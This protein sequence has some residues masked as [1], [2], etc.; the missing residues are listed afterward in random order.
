MVGAFT[1]AGFVGSGVLA[2]AVA[3]ILFGLVFLVVALA[4]LGLADAVGARATTLRESGMYRLTRNPQVVAG[5]PLIVGTTQ[6]PLAAISRPDSAYRVS[7]L[8]AGPSAPAARTI[9]PTLPG[10]ITRYR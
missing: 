7:V 10:S 8:V 6:S 1:F 3:L 4:Q 5:A 2:S 9:V